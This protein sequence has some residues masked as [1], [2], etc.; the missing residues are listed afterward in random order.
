MMMDI[1]DSPLFGAVLFL[2][3]MEYLARINNVRFYL[4]DIFGAIAQGFEPMFVVGL[5]N[6]L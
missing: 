4:F 1:I 5:T 2:H 6:T 3:Q